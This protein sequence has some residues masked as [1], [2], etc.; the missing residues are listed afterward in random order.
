MIQDPKYG[1]DPSSFVQGKKEKSIEVPKKRENYSSVYG[2]DGLGIKPFSFYGNAESTWDMWGPAENIL[3]GRVDPDFDAVYVK[4]AALRPLGEAKTGAFSLSFVA[5]AFNDMKSA[6]AGEYSLHGSKLAGTP[7]A[8]IEARKGWINP[9]DLHNRVFEDLFKD[10]IKLLL[11]DKKVMNFDDFMQVFMDYHKNVMVPRGIRLLRSNFMLSRMSSPL[12]SGM[13]IEISQDGHERDTNKYSKW[14]KSPGYNV[15]REA[16]ANYGFMVDKN[17]PWRLVANLNSPKMQNYLAGQKKKGKAVYNTNFKEVNGNLVA[18]DV[19]DVYPMFYEKAYRK[20]IGIMIQTMLN[21]YNEFV[22]FRPTTNV[23]MQSQ[24]IKRDAKQYHLPETVTKSVKRNF[25]INSEGSPAPELN[26][27]DDLYWLNQYF[28]IR[29][30]EANIFLNE[31]RMKRQFRR[32]HK[33]YRYL[34][35]EKALT[36]VNNYVR[37]LSP[38]R[39]S[40]KVSVEGASE[41]AYLAAPTLSTSGQAG[42]AGGYGN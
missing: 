5:K 20:D 1:D 14:L 19:D 28:L 36:H 15:Y 34:G 2:I 10:E 30:A 25:I 29:M 9:A 40:I 16:A 21:M 11:E 13:V 27:Y 6:L 33:M 18:L 41:A 7:Y 35:Y 12:I 39:P 23:V 24:C 31:E 8:K 17:A 26:K 37:L 3:Y 32:V 38:P 22:R 42:S 4:T